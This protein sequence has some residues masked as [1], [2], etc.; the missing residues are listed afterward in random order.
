MHTSIV[1]SPGGRKS[2]TE[3][4]HVPAAVETR[5]Y[6]YPADATLMSMT[7]LTSH[8]TYANAAFL[9]VSGFSREAMLGRPHNLVRHPDTPR[10]AF[11][12]LW[13]TLKGGEAWSAMV[14]NSRSDGVHHYWVWANVT[15]VRVGERVVGYMSVRTRPTAEEIEATSALYR[16]FLEG[17]A[18]GL[19][20]HKG[21]I[22]RTGLLGWMRIGQVLPV[23]WRLR[24]ALAGVAVAGAIPAALGW[25]PWVAVTPVVLAVLA[26]G[27]W[28]EAGVERP[29][30][31]ILAQAKAIAAGHPGNNVQM[32]RVDEIGMTLRA[33]NQAGLNLRAL[34][35]D[36]ARQIEGMQ[37]GN[38]QIAQGNAD[39]KWRTEQ[40]LSKLQETAA[41]A[42]QISATVAQGAQIASTAH[43]LASSA[44]QAVIDGGQTIGK[45][46]QSMK[47]IARSNAQIAEVNNLVDSIAFQTN[48][49]ALNA[50][51]E[52]ARAGTSGRGFAVVASEVRN[53]AQRS[54]EAAKGIKQLTDE[55]VGKSEAGV[56]QAEQAGKVMEGIVDEVRRVSSLIAEISASANE[57]S[58]GVS[59]VSNAV[60]QIDQMTRDN[61][62]LVRQSADAVGEML[63]RA[64]RLAEAVRAFD[65]KSETAVAGVVAPVL[66]AQG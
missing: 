21:L 28:L 40:T 36:V 66:Q 32:N 41:A 53:L 51:V 50:A 20:F 63:E 31:Y 3:S 64:S 60:V 23:R 29:L 15:P 55:N 56:R 17:R 24:L 2:V 47:D 45:V 18:R 42:E 52:A 14:K 19:A 12:D 30:R 37:S 25:M 27:L 13:A 1:T 58:V 34:M 10:E 57:Q 48:L 44:S 49:L 6:S 26:A 5:N 16:R 59:Q 62:Q 61:G 65:R 4:M 46:V 39:L 11:A 9:D 43:E 8:I 22:V 35:G 33:V 7:N 38:Q 54:A